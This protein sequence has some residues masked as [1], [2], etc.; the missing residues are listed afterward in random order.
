M[1][2]LTQLFGLDAEK[3]AEV[4]KTLETRFGGLLRWAKYIMPRTSNNRAAKI[5]NRS[6]GKFAS[7]EVAGTWTGWNTIAFG[8]NATVEFESVPCLDF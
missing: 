6:L 8:A 1:F 3:K 7:M 4:C 2:F 5:E